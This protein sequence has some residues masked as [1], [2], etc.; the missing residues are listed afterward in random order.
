MGTMNSR[1]TDAPA[2]TAGNRW[3]WKMA[4]IAGIDIYIHATFLLIIAWVVMTHWLQGQNVAAT[5]DGI[6]FVLAIFAC[7]VLHELGHALT[8]RRYGIRTHDIILYP[9]GGV[10]RL[11]RL[12]EKPRQELWVALAGPA[13]NVVIAAVLFGW[14][15]ITSTF[16]PVNEL[17]VTG[18]SFVERLLVA[19][20][21]L[22]GFNLIPAFP[23]DGGRVLRALLASRME[24]TRATQIAASTGQAF[25]LL[26]GIVGLFGNPLLIFVAL[27]VWIGASA[28][29]SSV[30]MRSSLYGIPVRQAM[31]TTFDTI[32]PDDRLQRAVDRILAGAQQDF[33]VVNNGRIEGILTRADLLVALTRSGPETPVRNVMQRSYSEAD[34]TEML[35]TAF[36]RLGTCD[37]HTM[38]V[39]HGGQL[40]GLLT[41][42]NVGEFLA[43]NAALKHSPAVAGSV[44]GP[45]LA[46]AT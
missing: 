17:T 23:M 18:G 5:I 40:V 41:M 30:Q 19:N 2:R 31:M 9:I 46:P 36:A 39:T 35:E 4:T 24:Y 13:V 11:E 33:P 37:C 10:A 14:L 15:A 1:N 26:F 21:F 3:S 45:R 20:L 22:V 7:V 32:G 34:A 28:E 27:F 16:Q 25:A 29:A 43:I 12:P 44:D 8:A 6:V 38:P 42:E